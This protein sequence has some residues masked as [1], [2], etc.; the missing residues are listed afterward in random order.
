MLYDHFADHKA[1][2]NSLGVYFLLF[3]LVG[4]KESKNA[5]FVL[6]FNPLPIILYGNSQKSLAI[7]K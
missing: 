5:A 7:I 3:L 6:L 2:S 1:Q 4:A